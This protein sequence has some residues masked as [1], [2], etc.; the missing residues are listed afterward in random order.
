MAAEPQG[1]LGPSSALLPAHMGDG[2]SP[3]AVNTPQRPPESGRESYRAE[4]GIKESSPFWC[5]ISF[6]KTVSHYLRGMA[7]LQPAI[8]EEKV[9]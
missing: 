3:E 2:L 9:I 6:H 1:S 8:S 4:R 5:F 7:T